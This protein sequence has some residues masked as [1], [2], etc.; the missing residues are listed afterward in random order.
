M[1]TWPIRCSRN[2][3]VAGLMCVMLASCAPRLVPPQPEPPAPEPAPEPLPPP[4]PPPPVQ[5]QDAPATPGNWSWQAGS[6][7]SSARFTG[8]GGT[9]FQMECG[10]GRQISLILSGAAGSAITIRTSYGDRGLAARQ[11]AGGLVAQ[12]PANDALL[13]QIAFSRGHFA[14]EAQGR[15][16]L[17]LPAWGEPTRVIEDCRA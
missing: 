2:S 3:L 7:G 1:K 12:L 10:A 5:W 9:L 6:Q 16:R 15:S 17:I 11:D 14:V 13:D 4:P 8:S